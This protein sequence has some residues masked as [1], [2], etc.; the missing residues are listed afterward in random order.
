[1]A[2]NKQFQKYSLL[3]EL[4]KADEE[5]TGSSALLGMT[6]LSYPAYI[7]PMRSVMFTKHL[8][9]FLN[10]QHPDF[11]YVFTSGENLVGRHSSGYKK[12]KHKLT[13]FRKVVKFED[14]VENP[15]V[16]KLFVFDEETQKF[17]VITRNPVENLTEN[18]GYEY[19]NTVI[20]SFEEGDTIDKD[21]V[22]YNSSSY[23]EDMNYGFG[24]NVTTMYTLDLYTSEDAAVVSRSLA[25]QMTSIETETISIG[26]NDNDFLINLQGDKN[27]YKPLPD[28]GDYVS[29]HLAAVRRQFNNQLL[30]DFK[31]E[32]LNKIHEGDS[33]YYIGDNYQV[34]DYTIFNNNEEDI[35]ND[36]TKQINK[37][38]HGEI[39]YY[40]E[41]LNVCEEIIDSGYE[42]SRDIDYLYKRSKEMLDNKKK[43]KE[44]DHAF[45][46]MV[47]DIT[48]K[49]V[50]PLIKGQKITGRYGNKSVISEI[51]E[52]EDM[53]YTEDGRRVDLL[54][55]ML[56]IINRT[57]SFP[58][59]E[60]MITSICYKVRSRLAQMDNYK[61][62][63]ELLF[64]ILKMFNEDEYEQFWSLYSKYSENEKKQFIDDAINDG[65][66]IHQ[67]PLWE[68]KFIFHRIRDIL[69][70]YDWLKADTL[71]INKWGRKIKILS[72]YWIGDQYILKL[73][74]TS[75]NGF[76]ARSTGAVDN[77][78]LPTR[79]YKSRSHLEQY[80]GNPIR[81]G[82]YETLNFSIGLSPEDITLFNALYRTSIKGR[83]DLIKLMFSDNPD[84]IL[85]LDKSYTSRVAEIFNVI[86]KSLSLKLKFIDKDDMIYPINDTLVHPQTFKGKTIFCTDFEL[87]KLERR[88]EIKEDILKENPIIPS[89]ELEEMIEDELKNRNYILGDYKINISNDDE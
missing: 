87:F 33:I 30:F 72:N 28:I 35:D 16:Y 88:E 4:S 25:E 51:R 65:I 13:V 69:A 86:L 10:L 41:I 64:D 5:F 31:A 34:I 47:I 18:F 57:T 79:S 32:S 7:N 22:M 73:K 48:V 21:V 49:K 15:L 42:Y 11:P 55:N 89:I 12:A 29:G 38:L 39:K 75:T 17:E 58:L 82:E 84:K 20:D 19:N 71:Y 74:Q 81:F 67:P 61:D 36:F 68:K 80:S 63:E 24:K 62:R 52:D 56:A 54:L 40:Q 70:K 60:L 50:V 37:Y 53:P 83:K 85:E 14:F 27:N 76:I 46:N 6:I 3:D 9:Q 23:D 77:R 78:G 59:Y 26:L 44:G 66:Y 2:N 1:M 43:W 8:S 45:S